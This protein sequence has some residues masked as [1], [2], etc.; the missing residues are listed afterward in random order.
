M[1]LLARVKQLLETLSGKMEELSGIFSSVRGLILEYF[2]PNGLIATY[3]VLAV[4][5]LVIILQL[6]KI[7]FATI[8]YLVLP[9]AALAV[10]GSLVLPY[11]F[12]MLLPVTATACSLVLLFK[13]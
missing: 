13:A 8:K 11:S 3:V 2:G 9:A 4:L 10:L 1:D 5:A 6:V 12:F 7:S